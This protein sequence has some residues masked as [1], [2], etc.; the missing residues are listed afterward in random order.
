MSPVFRTGL[1]VIGVV[2]V[3]L[4]VIGIFVPVLPTTPFIILAA[5]CFVRSSKRA[6]DWL[7]R[8]P[9]FGKALR[10]WEENRSIARSNKIMAIVAIL[11][12]LIFIWVKVENDWVKYGVTILLLGVSIFIATRNESSK[13]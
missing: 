8:Q 9:L 11:V 10:N 4:G 2:S 13:G 7:Y 12:S 1:F 3:V 6:H 5:W